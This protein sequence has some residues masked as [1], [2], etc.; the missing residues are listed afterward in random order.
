M[1]NDK[2]LAQAELLLLTMPLRVY[3]ITL[4]K[5]YDQA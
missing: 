4:L 3:G 1:C 5:N 2:G